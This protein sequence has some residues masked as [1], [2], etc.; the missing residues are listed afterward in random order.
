MIDMSGYILVILVSVLYRRFAYPIGERQWYD[1]LAVSIMGI[2]IV[3][4]YRLIA[5]HHL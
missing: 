1:Y 3:G 4:V 2:I 5:Y